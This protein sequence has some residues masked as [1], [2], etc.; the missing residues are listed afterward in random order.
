[1]PRYHKRARF[2]TVPDT[3]H[4]RTTDLLYKL[5]C[6]TRSSQHLLCFT[7]QLSYHEFNLQIQKDSRVCLHSCVLVC[8][9]RGRS[10]YEKGRGQI[11]DNKLVQL[12][13]HL[14]RKVKVMVGMMHRFGPFTTKVNTRC[15]TM[16]AT[17]ST[18]AP[19]HPN[20][21]YHSIVFLCSFKL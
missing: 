19:L 18:M 4:A 11:P 14:C 17:C 2:G 6:D 21:A 9:T 16:G 3:T 15:I 20:L 5:E 8:T 1:M 12:Q 13:E 10:Y 7:K